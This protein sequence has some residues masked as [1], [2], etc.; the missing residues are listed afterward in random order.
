MHILHPRRVHSR[1]PTDHVVPRSE[2]P[3]VNP[4]TTVSKSGD[5]N[6]ASHLVARHRGQ[7]R[8]G[9]SREI[10]Y[11][12]AAAKSVANP[13][14][15]RSG[16]RSTQSHLDGRL[17]RSVPHSNVLDVATHEELASTLLPL[18]HEPGV[19]LVRASW[20]LFRDALERRDEFHIFGGFVSS[21]QS[22]VAVGCV[23]F[24]SAEKTRERNL[25]TSIP[26]PMQS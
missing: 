16:A 10:L 8:V 5:D 2:A 4:E 6:V 12:F 20:Q 17:P 13:N 3:V 23:T 21:E 1:I 22:H 19:L 18:D 14:S 7:A 25:E 11:T 24:E 26:H 15:Q 9:S